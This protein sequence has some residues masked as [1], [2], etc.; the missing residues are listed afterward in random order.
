[1]LKVSYTFLTRDQYPRAPIDNKRLFQETLSRLLNAI[2]NIDMLTTI[3]SVPEYIIL[4]SQQQKN[5]K[6][7]GAGLQ[8]KFAYLTKLIKRLHIVF[9]PLHLHEAIM[10]F[11]VKVQLNNQTCKKQDATTNSG[12]RPS[13]VESVRFLSWPKNIVWICIVH[14][15]RWLPEIQDSYKNKIYRNANISVNAQTLHHELLPIIVESPII[16]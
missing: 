6:L 16:Y 15:R 2:G 4:S 3:E 13:C 8:N 1:M 10:I 9:P 5:L 11:L 7:S 14:R 12:T